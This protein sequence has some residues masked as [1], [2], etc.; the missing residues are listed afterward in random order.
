MNLM[1]FD[2]LSLL[3]W[4]QGSSQRLP[5]WTGGHL[6]ETPV[7]PL[8]ADPCIPFLD[9][10]THCSRSKWR[11]GA[12]L[13][14]SPS[15]DLITGGLQPL[16]TSQQTPGFVAIS[17]C[18]QSLA[19]VWGLKGIW[20]GKGVLRSHSWRQLALQCSVCNL[21]VGT[22]PWSG[23][24]PQDVHGDL[25]AVT[26]VWR[27]RH[28]LGS[29]PACR[30]HGIY[31]TKGSLSF[32]VLNVIRQT[33]AEAHARKQNPSLQETFW[34]GLVGVCGMD[35]TYG[36]KPKQRLKGLAS[37]PW[38]LPE[39]AEF[40]RQ[41]GGWQKT[42]GCPFLGGYGSSAQPLW[43]NQFVSGWARV[44]GRSWPAGACTVLGCPIHT[45]AP[46]AQ[47]PS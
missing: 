19:G 10:T 43:K 23:R 16:F 5:H 25:W 47:P 29:R 34:G 45:P 4:F 31:C 37:S 44:C 1:S 13:C 11:P 41:P 30:W 21:E 33:L 32:Q 24:G 42:L 8:S 36:S 9:N 6:G 35:K 7:Q 14:H 28:W 15:A 46:G 17:G 22:E 27:R 18:S 40:R 20:F 3:L 38:G 26:Q 12:R 39:K 2:Q